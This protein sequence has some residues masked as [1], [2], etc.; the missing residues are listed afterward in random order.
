[1]KAKEKLENAISHFCKKEN[2]IKK[3]VWKI[4]NHYI[5]RKIPNNF[6]KLI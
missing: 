2:A 1:M 5:P 4:N 6:Q 3:R